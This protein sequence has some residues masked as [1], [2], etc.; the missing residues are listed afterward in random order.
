MTDLL[1]GRNLLRL[2]LFASFHGLHICRV[3]ARDASPVALE[4][5]LA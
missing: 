3:V 2:R 5:R 1:F 4:N